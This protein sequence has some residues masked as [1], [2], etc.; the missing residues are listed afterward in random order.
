MT[1]YD[2]S[3]AKEQHESWTTLWRESNHVEWYCTVCNRPN[4]YGETHCSGCGKIAPSDANQRVDDVAATMIQCLVREHLA[5][6]ALKA[7][8]ILTYVKHLDKACGEEYYE[9]TVTN[10]TSWFLPSFITSADLNN[11]E[12]FEEVKAWREKE[13]IKCEEREKARVEM[14]AERKE[15]VD[16]DNAAKEAQAA[17][18][19]A[20]IWE[21]VLEAARER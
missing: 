18:D 5:R 9:N 17:L 11:N 4:A 12:E 20:E 14:M 8:A 13:Q 15:K 21:P 7:K 3:E 2:E 19:L 6:A 10:A 16:A 1:D